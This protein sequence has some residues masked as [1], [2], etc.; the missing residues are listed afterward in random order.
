MMERRLFVL[1]RLSA[2]LMAPMVFVHLGLILYAVRG[3]LSAAEILQRTQD[4][5]G[6]AIFYGVFVVV[7]AVH[8][9]IG[10]RKIM[11]EWSKLP[12]ST[13]N[14]FC[15]IFALILLVLGFRAVVAVV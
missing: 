3:G 7:V 13:I 6:W 4:S 5:V 2:M 9:P 14:G 12:D 8:A 11:Q 1:Q 10:L 15:W